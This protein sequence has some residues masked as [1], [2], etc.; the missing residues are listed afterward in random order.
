MQLCRDLRSPTPHDS[1]VALGNFDGVHLGHASI[2]ARLRAL[3]AQRGLQTTVIT[4]APHPRDYFAALGRGAAVAHI[5]SQR[6]RLELLTA[7]GVNRVVLLR[8]N[9]ALAQLSAVDFVV[10]VLVNNCRARCVVVGRDVRF[11]HQRAGDLALLQVLGVQHGFDVVVLDDILTGAARVS[12]SAVRGALAA[13][14]ILTANRLLGRAYALS[15]R[16]IHGRKIG[17]TLG[18]PTLNVAI[19]LPRPAL[20]GIWVV[21]ILGLDGGVLNG[22]AS[23]GLRP[24]VEQT[25]RYS[26]EVHAFDWSGD[27]YGQRVEIV[28]LHKLRDEA[29]YVDLPTLQTAIEKDMGDARA[30]LA[31]IS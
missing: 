27:A 12:S 7:A 21:R 19:R 14:D 1:V 8:F 22:V 25:T 3:A 20:Q 28:F 24:T 10:Q 17:R 6:D 30:W 2:A 4:F 31:K 15:G 16:V 5:A 29:A 18:C 11:G 26:L 9:A 13:G 23:L